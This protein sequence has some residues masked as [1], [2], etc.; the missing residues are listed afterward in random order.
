MPYATTAVSDAAL[1]SRTLYSTV[2]PSTNVVVLCNGDN[3]C[4][5]LIDMQHLRKPA[6]D[7]LYKLFEYTDIPNLSSRT[8]NDSST[9]TDFNTDTARN[10]PSW[11]STGRSAGGSACGL[12][13]RGGLGVGIAAGTSRSNRCIISREFG[14][15]AKELQL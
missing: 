5:V 14:E 10:A 7:A 13:R 12:P 15:T 11:R 1:P 6:C 4:H 2:F 8:A 9:S 3:D